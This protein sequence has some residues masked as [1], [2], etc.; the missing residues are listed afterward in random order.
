MKLSDVEVGGRYT[1]KVSGR[2]V[3]VRVAEIVSVPATR[4]SSAKT[5]IEAVNEAT[6]R[7]ISDPL[8]PCGCAGASIAGANSA[9]RN[10]T[11][12]RRVSPA[13]TARPLGRRFP[14]S[15]DV[16]HVVAL[17]A[18]KRAS[19]SWI[20]SLANPGPPPTWGQRR[21]SAGRKTR[22]NRSVFSGR[23]DANSAL[24]RLMLLATRGSCVVVVEF[25]RRPTR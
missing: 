15:G 19:L 2:I 10:A 14:P 25:P 7:R 3:T 8:A 4:W 24:P 9:G 16:P 13:R 17:D 11:G 12:P 22:R 5:R 6:G 23:I 1:A 20:V 21:V 18:R